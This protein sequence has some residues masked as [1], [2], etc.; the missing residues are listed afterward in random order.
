MNSR[1]GDKR[2]IVM[3]NTFELKDLDKDFWNSVIFIYICHSSGMG[4]PGVLWL[5]TKEAKQY[6]VGL[7]DL[8]FNE[9][10]LEKMNSLFE[11]HYDEN[12][13]GRLYRIKAESQGF[14]FSDKG[15]V[16]VKEEYFDT[17]EKMWQKVYDLDL[18]KINYVHAPDVMG[19]VLGVETMERFDLD[20][21]VKRHRAEELERE[22]I[23]EECEKKKL[24]E[25]YFVWKP[26]YLNNIYQRCFPE[27]GYYC[28]L[29]KEVDG[30]IY[31]SRY[32]IV[33]Q[34]EQFQPFGYKSDAPIEQYIVFEKDYGVIEGRLSFDDPKEQ[35]KDEWLVSELADSLNDY[36]LN[37]PGKFERALPTMEDAKQYAMALAGRAGFDIENVVDSTDEKYLEQKK[38]ENTKLKMETILEFGKKYKEIME[39]VAEY[40]FPKNT[41]GG[42]YIKHALMEKLGMEEIIAK[43]MLQYIPQILL[44]KNQRKA[45]ELLDECENV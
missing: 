17:Y 18:Y 15:R 30:K 27:E 38:Y 1:S 29:L 23:K 41:G 21:T 8:P 22:R 45:K 26:I 6:V 34:K 32:S 11:S 19:Y 42:Y 25:D 12:A 7:V 4:G 28:L 14:K 16:Y 36:D 31:G 35:K 40:E 33:Y 39:L 43:N 20:K 24:T 5:I 2:R 13:R 3:E 9:Y 44:P 37:D 10:E